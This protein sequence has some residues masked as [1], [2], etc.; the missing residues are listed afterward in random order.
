MGFSFV[1]N[2]VFEIAKS[3]DSFILTRDCGPS[4][5]TYMLILR[6]PMKSLLSDRTRYPDEISAIR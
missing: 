1:K 6:Y 4:I 3:T 2:D 5:Y